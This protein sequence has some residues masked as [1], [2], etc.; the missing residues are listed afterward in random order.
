MFADGGSLDGQ[1]TVWGQV[2]SGMEFVDKIKAGSEENNGTV[3]D[4]D[5]IIRVQVAADADKK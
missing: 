3:Q 2:V 1:Y 4:P 5:K